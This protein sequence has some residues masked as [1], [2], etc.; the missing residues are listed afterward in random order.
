MVV[1]VMSDQTPAS[2]ASSEEQRFRRLVD[3]LDHAVVWEFDDTL[4]KYTFVSQHSLLVFGHECEDWMTNP[5]F[6][7][8]HVYPEDL[9]RIREVL[10]TLRAD[11]NV[12]NLRLEHRCIK[13]DGSVIWAHTGVHREVEAG[14]LLFRGVTVDVNSIKAAEER[15]REARSLAE[16]AVRARDEVLAVVSHDLRTPLNNIRL[17]AGLMRDNPESASHHLAII[18]RAV[19]RMES[20]INDLIDAATI[21]A[22]GLVISRTTLETATFVPQLVDE[23]R[24]MYQEQDVALS[25]DV[26]AHVTISCDARRITQVVSNLLHNALKF[27]G[28]GGEVCLSVT[29]SNLEATFAVRDSGRGIQKDDLERVFD[30][31]WQAEETAHLGS[32]MGL[33][34]AKG[35][36]E[37]HAGRIWVESEP[38]AGS[39]FAFTLP[40]G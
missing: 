13:A 22:H 4:K 39:V 34:I 20:L 10:A 19:Q 2:A 23:F 21:R 28:P 38:G 12:N 7:E 1:I 11:A 37:A 9:A 14:H 31:A 15:E 29:A 5:A 16:R 33:Y 17:A 35:I 25:G 18:Q 27:T 36:V 26:Q 8:E 40:L 3:A 32:G 6:L 30:R 24:A